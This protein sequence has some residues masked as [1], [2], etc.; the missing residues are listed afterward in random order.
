[1]KYVLYEGS[2]AAE[3]EAT[4]AVTEG[5][6]EPVAEA[7]QEEVSKVSQFISE[8]GDRIVAAI[9]SIILALVALIVGLIAAK[10]ISKIISKALKR[11]KVDGAAESFLI[12]L[13]RIILYIVVVIM[14]LG[15]L[16]VPMS[17]II[18]VFGA[19]GLAISLALQNCLTNLCGGFIILFSKPFTA[20]DTIELDG[21][22]GEV[23]TISILYTKMRTFDGKTVL[24]PNGKV[25]EAKIV[26]YTETPTR[27]IELKFGIAYEADFEKARE[28]INTVI[29][30]NKLVLRDPEPIV[31]MSAHNE[32]SVSIDTYVWVKNED[33]TT[34]KYSLIESVKAEFDRN[35]IE[36]PYNK[37]DIQIKEQK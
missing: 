19:A 3:T 16:K 1:M 9:P 32:S 22:V 35:S 5:A 25:T 28:L 6:T 21:S 37:I 23:D 27:R 7:I 36:I 15:L 33:F 2:T 26:N 17:S 4:E 34:V 29:E 18:T 11:T 8:I 20:G 14:A 31:R 13:I 12:S 24:I 10:L 30:G